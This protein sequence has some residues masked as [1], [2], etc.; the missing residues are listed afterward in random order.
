MEK[1]LSNLI[2]AVIKLVAMIIWL[3]LKV[4]KTVLEGI[5]RLMEYLIK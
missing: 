3:A 4:L 5:I 2:M 1:L